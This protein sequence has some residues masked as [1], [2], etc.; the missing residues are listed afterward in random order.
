VIL[1]ASAVLVAN[2]L[3]NWMPAL[4]SIVYHLALPQALR[5]ASMTNVAQVT[6]V[7]M[8]AMVIDRTGRKYWTKAPSAWARRRWAS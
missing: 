7:F 4:Y 2:G 1:W 6:L 5:A 8:C 3:N